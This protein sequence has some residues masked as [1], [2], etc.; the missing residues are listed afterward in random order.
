MATP[1]RCMRLRWQLEQ[2]CPS[3]T[4][5]RSTPSLSTGTRVRLFGATR[6][7]CGPRAP[8]S[9][10]TELFNGAG[11]RVLAAM[12]AGVAA[13]VRAGIVAPI[14][15]FTS[16]CGATSL[17][18]FAMPLLHVDA[19]YMSSRRCKAR[20]PAEGW[21][22][23]CREAPRVARSPRAPARRTDESRLY[24]APGDRRT[25]I[26]VLGSSTE[27]CATQ[28]LGLGR[29]PI[30]QAR[31][32]AKAGCPCQPTPHPGARR[33]LSSRFP[34]SYLRQT[35]CCTGCGAPPAPRIAA[36]AHTRSIGDVR[37]PSGR[38]PC[39]A[40]GRRFG[41]STCSLE[42]RHPWRAGLHLRRRVL[43]LNMHA[44]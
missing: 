18:A 32:E 34:D 43:A 7:R 9:G 14:Q 39:L 15:E 28:P 33:D 25:V 21:L 44:V 16:F 38:R 12:P 27:G 26:T 2:A 42:P 29:L 3:K 8:P 30:S 36:L 41:P 1:A 24:P 40:P 5:P 35:S 10:P 17:S 19:V 13:T 23:R 6:R 20:V 11:L 22:T 37:L 31:Q 4:W